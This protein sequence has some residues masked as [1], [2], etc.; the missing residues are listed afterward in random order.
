MGEG[1][2]ESSLFISVFLCLD[3]LGI[4]EIDGATEERDAAWPG[5][6]CC[7]KHKCGCREMKCERRGRTAIYQKELAWGGVLPSFACMD[8][9][10]KFMWKG[11]ESAKREFMCVG[12]GVRG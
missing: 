4:L 3:D 10:L 12:S 5:R 2:F 11:W 6:L 7:R 9:N 1:R 8:G